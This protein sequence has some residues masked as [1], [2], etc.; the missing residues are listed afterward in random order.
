MQQEEDL[1]E[2]EA[3]YRRGWG[4]G[5]TEATEVIV[6]L[7]ELGYDRHKIRQYMA[8][9]DDHFVSEWR[10]NGDLEKREPFPAFNVQQIEEIAT[11]HRGYDWLL[12][13]I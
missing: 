11:T 3:A 4:H 7:L 2:K 13:D 8:I 5:C 6:R 1:I 9:Y 12:R 10:Q